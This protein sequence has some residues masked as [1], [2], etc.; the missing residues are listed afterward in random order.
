M[1]LKLIN[2]PDAYTSKKSKFFLENLCFKIL[3]K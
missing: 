1:R 2:E 3:N